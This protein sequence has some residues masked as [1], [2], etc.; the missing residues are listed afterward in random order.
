MS[1]RVYANVNLRYNPKDL[2]SPV[3]LNDINS[4]I[5][6]QLIEDGKIMIG[7]ANIRDDVILRPV[8]ANADTTRDVFD[9]L[10]DE[11]VRLGDS[12]TGIEEIPMVSAN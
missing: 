2:T 8:F 10:L 5:R 12:I 7:R 3:D 11:I 6:K 1:K 9:A 4:K